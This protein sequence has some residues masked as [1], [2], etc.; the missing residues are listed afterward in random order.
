M[1]VDASYYKNTFRGEPVDSSDF[2]ALLDRASEIIEEM[3]MYR[4]S[5]EKMESYEKDI[6][7]RIKRAVC[8]EIEFLNA[9]GGSEVD[10]GTE[11]QSAALG[12][13]NYTKASGTSGDGSG[14]KYIAPRAVRI[15]M[16]TGLLYRGG[17]RLCKQSLK[18]Y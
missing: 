5:P 2:P 6:Q 14:S 11:L 18:D 15:L 12:K 13:F 17:R 4:I 16:H 1:Y 10:N 9:N 3:C 8:A 7:E